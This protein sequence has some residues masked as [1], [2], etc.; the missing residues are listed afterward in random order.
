ML[1][2]IFILILSFLCYK[3]FAQYQTID[4]FNQF[5]TQV[6]LCTDAKNDYVLI[7]NGYSE[8]PEYLIIFSDDK[9]SARQVYGEIILKYYHIK[10]MKREPKSMNN[11]MYYSILDNSEEEILYLHSLTDEFILISYNM[12]YMD[13]NTS[14]DEKVKFYDIADDLYKEETLGSA[15][16]ILMGIRASDFV[17]MVYAYDNSMADSF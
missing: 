9:Y 10:N 4:T 15:A 11:I 17:S 2:R 14:A 3:A 13:N 7:N 1:K 5:Y 16:G 12:F 8:Y 6:I